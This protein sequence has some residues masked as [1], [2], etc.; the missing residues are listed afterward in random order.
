MRAVS[1]DYPLW[2]SLE[3]GPYPIGFRL[4][5]KT[6]HSRSYSPK[7]EYDY[8]SQKG[9]RDRRIRM[10]VWYPA[11]KSDTPHMLFIQYF[12]LALD[13][14]G[15]RQG[16]DKKEIW[17]EL[18][19]ARGLSEKSLEMLLKTK[20]P[21]QEDANPRGGKF[22]LIVFGQGLYYESPI[23]HCI[24]CEYLASHGYVVAT[25]PLNG[26]YSRL[27]K[28]DVIDLET[29]V[30]DM[31]FVISLARGC[32][33]VDPNK[34]GLIGFDL[35]GM[36]ALILA[37]RNTD[38]DAFASLD[39]G[40]LFAHP[41]GLPQTSPHYNVERFRIPWMHMTRTEAVKNVP[42]TQ[43]TDFLFETKKYGDSYLIL[44]DKTRHV[45]FTSYSMYG[46]EKTV[47][48]YWGPAPGSPPHNYRIICDYVQN[49][50]DAYLK[51]DQDGL[52]FMNKKFVEPAIPDAPYTI[53]KKKGNKAPPVFDDFVRWIFEEGYTKAQQLYRQA[54]Q[55]Y[56]GSDLFDEAKINQLAYKFLYFWGHVD[57]AIQIFQLNV[58]NH[59]RSFNV[60]DSL[61]EAYMVKGDTVHA[62]EN[63]EKSLALNPEN[64]N[65][66]EMLRR[67][68]KE[69][70][71]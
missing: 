41:S 59:S 37:M 65:A 51:G 12:H 25:C 33:F 61:A 14:F 62:I 32:E 2:G 69:D 9:E 56:P 29:Q 4:I 71:Y 20:T 28:L 16:L 38:V 42:R 23:T 40:I 10:Y 52:D 54:K 21:A 13:D 48:A 26:T 30:R 1:E 6:D 34:L 17:D 19:L 39:A 7:H 8:Q 64:S 31:E 35:G 53:E 27:V 57:I 60:Y 44:L 43:N 55:R 24:L 49:F 68:R 67:L 11:I 58:E 66:V 22:P 18:P 46:I 3:K 50:F 47:P 5:E 15:V 36:S 70:N 63:Y 45:D